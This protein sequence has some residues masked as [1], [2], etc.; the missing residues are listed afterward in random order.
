MRNCKPIRWQHKGKGITFMT[1]HGYRLFKRLTRVKFLGN[2]FYLT[3]YIVFCFNKTT[4]L[5]TK[6]KW[7]Y[8]KEIKHSICCW[9]SKLGLLKKFYSTITT[10]L[11]RRNN[12]QIFF[13]EVF[14]IW[15]SRNYITRINIIYL[16]RIL[17]I[18]MTIF[19]F[20]EWKKKYWYYLYSE[21]WKV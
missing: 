12:Y 14:L 13:G 9:N 7:I 2:A 3:L 19:I 5:G 17:N 15:T 10:I 6:L 1:E 4:E 20:R 8:F 18:K 16:A 11:G 21:K